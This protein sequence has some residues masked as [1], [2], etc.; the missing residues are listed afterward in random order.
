M[1]ANDIRDTV[2]P[3]DTIK[4]AVEALHRLVSRA[5]RIASVARRRY[6]RDKTPEKEHIF[7]LTAQEYYYISKLA[8]DFRKAALQAVAEKHAERSTS[9]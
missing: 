2:V 9:N 4:E 7:L 5:K 8:A 1:D 3:G 6:E